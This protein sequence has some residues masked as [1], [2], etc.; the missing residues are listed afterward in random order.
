[1]THTSRVLTALGILLLGAGGGWLLASR[2]PMADPGAAE[3]TTHGEWVSYPNADGQTVRAYV[4]YPE[5][6]GKA[7]AIIVI[8][9]IF[10]MTDWEPTVADDYASK[11]YVAIVPDLLSS[12]FGSTGDVADSARRLVSELSRES[13]VR[14]LDATYAYVNAQPATEPDNTGVIGFCW[15]G[16]SVWTYASHNPK[17]KAA[18]VCYGPLADTTMLRTVT[19]PVLGVYG[20]NDGRVTNSLPTIARM[21]QA[22]GKSFVADSYPGT[23]H[24]FLKPGRKGSDTPAAERARTVIAEFFAKQL[25][26]K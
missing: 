4:A 3:P 21:M 25:E 20:E 24:G 18:V 9:E 22:M 17:L 8:H 1:M 11:G 16:G 7:P 5:R 23:G 6:Q 12:R 14:D 13:V 26:G 10:G 19:A 2:A 15:G